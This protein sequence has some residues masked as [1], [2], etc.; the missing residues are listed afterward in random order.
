[1]SLRRN[2]S[3]HTG[4]TLMLAACLQISTAAAQDWTEYRNQRFG[5]H[6]QYP[7]DLFVVERTSDGGDGQLFTA[8]EGDARLLVGALINDSGYS[9]ASYQQYVS[10]HSYRDYHITY[11]RSGSSW[12]VL[13]GEGRGRTFYEKVMFSCEGRLINSFAMIYSSDQ[14]DVFDPMVERM[15][16]TFRPGRDCERAGLSSAPR[17]TA[18]GA[19]A[20]PTPRVEKEHSALANR[21][22]RARGRNVIVILRRTTPP[23]DTKVVHGYVSRQ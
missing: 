20:R 17:N 9:P 3:L 6:L 10:R 1:M 21:I 22:A 23:Y 19:P 14:R 5:F 18:A 4:A 12:F 15:G 16:N 8:K 7:A 11:Q 13:S 2:A